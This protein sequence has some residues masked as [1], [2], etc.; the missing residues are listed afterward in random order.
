MSREIIEAIRKISKPNHLGYSI[1]CNVESVDLTENTCYCSPINGDADLVGVRLIADNQ[2][3]R[4][5]V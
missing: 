5:H 4:A 2:I 3:G 1:V